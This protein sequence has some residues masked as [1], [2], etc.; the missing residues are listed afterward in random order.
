MKTI[1]KILKNYKFSKREFYF[2]ITLGLLSEVLHLI[3]PQFIERMIYVIETS[4]ILSD[5]Y[6]WCVLFAI[7]VVGV[8]IIGYLSDYYSIKMWMVNNAN[9]IQYYRQQLFKK[10]YKDIM[11]VGTG[12]LITRF[13]E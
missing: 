10:N 8:K 11:E 9:K 5:L 2:Y 12:K 3:M 4:K 6:Y 1:L 7:F 13:G